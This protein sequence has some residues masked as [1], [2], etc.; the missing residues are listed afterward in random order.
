MTV[1]VVE[2]DNGNMACFSSEDTA[3]KIEKWILKELYGW[4]DPNNTKK[5]VTELLEN[6]VVVYTSTTGYDRFMYCHILTVE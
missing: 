3:N 4:Y 6:Q 1:Y 5:L 2:T